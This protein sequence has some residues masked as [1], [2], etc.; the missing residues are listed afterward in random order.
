MAVKRGKE[1]VQ[2]GQKSNLVAPQQVPLYLEEYKIC[3]IALHIRNASLPLARCCHNM[4]YL[5]C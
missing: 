3:L 4:M 2:I 5:P 1:Y